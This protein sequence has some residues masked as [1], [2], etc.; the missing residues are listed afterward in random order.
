MLAPLLCLWYQTM[1]GSRRWRSRLF[2][3][4]SWTTFKVLPPTQFLSRNV[5][6]T[7]YS[8]CISLSAFPSSDLSRSFPR[9]FQSL[10]APPSSHGFSA[11]IDRLACAEFSVLHCPRGLPAKQTPARTLFQAL[12]SLAPAARPGS[13][14]SFRQRC[15]STLSWLN[16]VQG[17]A[18]AHRGSI[19]TWEA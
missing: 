8:A 7:E 15:T 5:E 18:P 19:V 2:V 17:Y 11:K 3:R 1:R 10:V 4:S 12:T 6:R 16:S 13:R 9:S 14:L